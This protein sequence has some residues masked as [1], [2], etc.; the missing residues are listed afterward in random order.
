MK[1]TLALSLLCISMAVVIAAP[2]EEIPK[3]DAA[4]T[5]EASIDFTT[6][7]RPRPIVTAVNGALDAI[8]N[9]AQNAMNSGISIS[10]GIIT[11]GNQ[12]G[13]SAASAVNT[14]V[15]GIIPAAAATGAATP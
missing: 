8:R 2:A 12:L 6:T 9:F 1:F 3:A 11:T 13:A 7:I 4:P 5:T 10:Q 14:A 15:A